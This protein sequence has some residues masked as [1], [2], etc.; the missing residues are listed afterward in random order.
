MFQTFEFERQPNYKWRTENL[1]R[2]GVVVSYP[3]MRAEDF[4]K[5]SGGVQGHD[6]LATVSIPTHYNR[7]LRN[8]PSS[9]QSNS[10]LAMNPY[11]VLRANDSR[12]IKLPYA[13]SNYPVDENWPIDYVDS[14]GDVAVLDEDSLMELTRFNSDLASRKSGSQTP[15]HRPRCNVRYMSCVLPRTEISIGTNNSLLP[16]ERVAGEVHSIYQTLVNISLQDGD[17]HITNVA[18]P[19]TEIT[20]MEQY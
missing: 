3:L 4:E 7:V 18:D 14:Q 9:S 13:V 2:S 11:F 17:V 15:V 16:Y 1:T 5:M 10:V 12:T 19:K 20:Y 8:R 6:L